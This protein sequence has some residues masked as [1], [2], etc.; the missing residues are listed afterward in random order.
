M[1]ARSLARKI[2]H[3]E[4]IKPASNELVEYI[5]WDF[6]GW[7][8]FFMRPDWIEEFKEQLHAAFKNLKEKP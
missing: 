6:T 7:P 2:A 4:G 3:E 5:M 8:G 1:N